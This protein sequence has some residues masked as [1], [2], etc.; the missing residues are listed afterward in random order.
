MDVI[1]KVTELKVNANY[2]K[3]GMTLAPIGD[4]LYLV[5]VPN[6]CQIDSET[7]EKVFNADGIRHILKGLHVALTIDADRQ[8]F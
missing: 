2:A 3:S 6:D 1:L 5:S 4:I 8:D 7:G